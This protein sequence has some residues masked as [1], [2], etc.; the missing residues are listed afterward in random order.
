MVY[1]SQSSVKMTNTVPSSSCTTPIDWL[2]VVPSFVE[3][4]CHP[5]IEGEV[6]YQPEIPGEE[7]SNH[8]Y[9]FYSTIKGIRTDPVSQ[10]QLITIPTEIL[11]LFFRYLGFTTL[12]QHDLTLIP[13]P[14][15][16]TKQLAVLRLVCHRWK[17]VVDTSP[18]CQF[19][20]VA[21]IKAIGA[22]EGL[23]IDTSATT[24]RLV[25]S[26]PREATMKAQLYV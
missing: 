25:L 10:C 20:L 26:D 19:K 8:R 15:H 17:A 24:L 13:S 21:R 22:E 12:I 7:G 4:L 18:A 11:E 6:L 14:F 16:S 9:L 1:L 3:L 2:L 5:E 23:S